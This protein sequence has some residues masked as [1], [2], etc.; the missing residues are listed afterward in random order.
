MPQDSSEKYR[1]SISI[2]KETSKTR[3]RRASMIW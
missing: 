2:P 3:M 1:A